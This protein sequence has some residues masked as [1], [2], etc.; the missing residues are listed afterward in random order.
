VDASLGALIRGHRLTAGLTQEAL[1]ERAGLSSQAVGALERGDRRFPHRETVTRLAEALRL[2]DDQ[3]AGLVEAARRRGTPRRQAPGPPRPRQL[4]PDIAHFTGRAEIVEAVCR[5]LEC[6]DAVAVWAV[7]GMGGVGK[8]ALSV[9]IGHRMAARFPDGQLFLDLRSTAALAPREA[10]GQLLRALGATKEGDA[11]DLDEAAARLRSVL[12]G[13]RTLLI[14]DNAA[15][16]EQVAPLLPGTAGCAA[17]I[18]SRRTLDAL[19]Q[20]R[21]VRLDVLSDAESLALLA[22]NAGQARVDAEPEAAARIVRYCA[23]LPLALRL[24]G[25]RL[26][27]R[28]AHRDAVGF[29]LDIEYSS[30]YRGIGTAAPAYVQYKDRSY[31][32][33]W[34]LY[35]YNQ[36]PVRPVDQLFDHEGDW[37][38]VAVLLDAANNPTDVVYF[39]HGGKCRVSW[40]KAPKE[41]EHPIAYSAKGTH[42]SYRS[43]GIHRAGIDQTSAGKPWRTW[44]NLRLVDDEPW[45]DYGGGWCDV[46]QGPHATGPEGP[47][48]NRNVDSVWD[49]QPCGVNHV[50]EQLLGE[51]KSLRPVNQPSADNEYSAELTIRGGT[52]EDSPIGSSYYPGLECRGDLYL[53]GPDR[54]D[55]GRD[56]IQVREVITK[57]PLHKCGTEVDISLTR[58]HYLDQLHYTVL[59]GSAGPATL[60]PK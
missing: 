59:D 2:T 23:G 40:S 21:H 32:M 6:S 41:G 58:D 25:A 18:T 26:A 60:T 36:Q 48:R 47:H 5:G 17:L 11:A 1:A 52:T 4:P 38:R 55:R 22:A 46:G 14:L 54:D 57:Q 27:A 35:A 34:L 30:A 12:A 8:T 51:W 7:A 56:G 44:Q 29:F 10:V 28:P 45:R 49:A 19:P 13:R 53:L 39:G 37:E 50:P 15:S 42:A 33:Y 43:P 31:V 3:H 20:A 9:H 16:V 24:A